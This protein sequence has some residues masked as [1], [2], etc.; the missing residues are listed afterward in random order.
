MTLT[1][2]DYTSL[3]E[4]ITK[5]TGL[6]LDARRQQEIVVLAEQIFSN[7]PSRQIASLVHLLAQHPTTHSYWQ[8]LLTQITVGETYFYRNQ[9]QVK[10]L[11]FHILPALIDQRRQ[12]GLKQLFFWS[13]GCAT[14]E[15][16]Y[17]LAM[18]LRE[19]LPDIDQWQISILATDINETFLEQAEAGFYR[20]WSFRNETPT[21]LQQ[22]WFQPEGSGFR[23]SETIRRMVRFKALNLISDH[24]PSLENGTAHLDLIMCRNVTIYFSQETTQE[25]VNRFQQSLNEDGWLIVGHSE[26]GFSTYQAF[27]THNFENTIVYQKKSQTKIKAAPE[28]P[29][30][31]MTPSY[32]TSA[33]SQ[34]LNLMSV[35]AA[36]SLP[37]SKEEALENATAA[38]NTEQWTDALRW[39]E[40]AEGIDR[41][42]PY[43]HYLRGVIHLNQG[44][45][46]EAIRSLHRAIY[47]DSGFTLAHF[48]LGEIYEQKGDYENCVRHWRQAFTTTAEF[49]GESHLPYCEDLSVNALRDLIT[50]R[51]QA[52][53]R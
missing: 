10:A 34:K 44:D 5:R 38:A 20:S 22:H 25:V 17:T 6:N 7:L 46:Q 35:Y 14:G 52:A 42:E 19:L 4:L 29:T 8:Q 28:I 13:A 50:H 12:S 1:L 47:C 36:P 41:L 43:I 2:T 40:V 45:S 11:R 26:P 18:L 23:L 33:L 37:V 15:E 32:E 31:P 3:F 24:Y 27:T 49:N 39:L 21:A 53:K 30:A 48:M 51:I 16:P 9:D